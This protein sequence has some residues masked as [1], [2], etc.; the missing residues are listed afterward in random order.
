[1]SNSGAKSLNR[2]FVMGFDVHVTVHPD[3]F[4]IIKPSRCTNFSKCYFG[5]KLCMFRTAL[6]S[7]I[8][9][10]SLYTQQWYMSSRFADSSQ[11]VSKPV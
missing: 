9:S 8:R 6:L 3:K 7:I 10:F 11:S 2:M 5:M 1:M 4:L